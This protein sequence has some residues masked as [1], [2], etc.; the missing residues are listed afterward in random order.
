[1]TVY[2]RQLKWIILLAAFRVADRKGNIAA[3]ESIVNKMEKLIV[4]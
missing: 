2:Q 1:M 4:S 3:M